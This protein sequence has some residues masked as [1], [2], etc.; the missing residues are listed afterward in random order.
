MITLAFAACATV[1]T[2]AEVTETVAVAAEKSAVAAAA[3]NLTLINGKVNPNAQV[4]FYL[5]SASWCGP[6]R[7][8]MPDIVETYKS[9]IADG[10]AEVILISYD[11]T[12]E[13][14]VK[15]VEHYN[16]EMP[17]VWAKDAKLGTLPGFVRATGIPFV[18]AVDAEG[19]VLGQG[20]PTRIHKWNTMVK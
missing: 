14:A 8:V 4:Y 17:A 15:Y 19:N 12:N 16:T 7:A 13:A 5:H 1:A 9:I 20:A 18:V 3:E 2:C 11:R 6:C 10:R